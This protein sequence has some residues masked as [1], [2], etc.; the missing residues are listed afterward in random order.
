MNSKS[1]L[2]LSIFLFLLLVL[3][4]SC[5]QEEEDIIISNPKL[6]LSFEYLMADGDGKAYTKVN[7]S[8]VNRRGAFWYGYTPYGSE[9][10]H[11]IQLS[12]SIY[13]K[14]QS[15]SGDSLHIE[16]SQRA[17]EADAELLVLEDTEENSWE[18]AWD[19]KSTETEI[20]NFWKRP[21]WSLI[22]NNTYLVPE[23]FEVVKAQKVL[24]DGVEKTYLEIRFSGETTGFY[25]APGY[26]IKNGRF[27]GVIE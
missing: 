23:V 21:F 25:G 3:L 12:K 9:P 20:E 27:K 24:F 19:Y 13:F 6:V 18:R 7:T 15:E 16:L 17:T 4:S 2:N 8:E 10:I 11:D 5:I 1:F 26:I 22:I 14:L